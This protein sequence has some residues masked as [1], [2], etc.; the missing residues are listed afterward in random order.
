MMRDH[1]SES[2]NFDQVPAR[3]SALP[4]GG[5]CVLAGDLIEHTFV[6]DSKLEHLVDALSNVSEGSTRLLGFYQWSWWRA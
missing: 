4:T 5:R 6:L 1:C 2:L 3:W